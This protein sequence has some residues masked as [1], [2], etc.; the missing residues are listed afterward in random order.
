MSV[1]LSK[2]TLIFTLSS[3]KTDPSLPG[4]SDG[5]SGETESSLSEQIP[6]MPLFCLSVVEIFMVFV[7]SGRRLASARADKQKF[8]EK[9]N[10]LQRV[11]Q[12][13]DNNM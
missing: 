10:S 5:L 7:S 3:Q 2:H 1:F 4:A 9:F 12:K 13:S 8:I 11:N 6:N